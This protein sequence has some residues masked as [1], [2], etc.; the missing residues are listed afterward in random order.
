MVF[1]DM[2]KDSSDSP[3]TFGTRLNLIA[4]NRS[5]FSFDSGVSMPQLSRYINGTSQPT[6]DKL[7]AMAEAGGVSLDWLARGLGQRSIKH[8]ENRSLSA[9]TSRMQSAAKE[10]DVGIIAMALGYDAY[11][12]GNWLT[13]KEEPTSLFIKDFCD[14]FSISTD[15][16]LTGQPA[17]STLKVSE[18][19]ADYQPISNSEVRIQDDNGSVSV[20]VDI[21]WIESNSLEIKDLYVY[22]VSDEAMKPTLQ[23]GDNLLLERYSHQDTTGK[24]CDGL[25]PGDLPPCDGIYLIKTGNSESLRRVFVD[26][27]GGLQVS[28]DANPSAVT[29]VQPEQVTRLAILAK[30]VYVERNL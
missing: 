28:S 9:V 13:G 26:V 15:F 7:I 20:L 23:P 16:I 25:A 21:D 5:K 24:T 22:P 1:S 29:H 3:S 18:Q 19:P 8:R 10:V 17:A 12:V 6:L 11:D 2:K 4:D 27:L 14:Y 30:A